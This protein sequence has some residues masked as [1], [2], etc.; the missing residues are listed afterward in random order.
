MT[1]A[2]SMTLAIISTISHLL[3]M[4]LYASSHTLLTTAPIYHSAVE[5]ETEDQRAQAEMVVR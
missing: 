3:S 4:G 2:E 5:K 1:A